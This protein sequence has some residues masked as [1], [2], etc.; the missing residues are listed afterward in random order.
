MLEGPFCTD[1][2]TWWRVQSDFYQVEG[3]VVEHDGT[4]VNLSPTP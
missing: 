4:E 2:Y 3:W 1:T